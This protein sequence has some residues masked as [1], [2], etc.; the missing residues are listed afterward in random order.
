MGV[1]AAR[2]QRENRLTRNY[3]WLLPVSSSSAENLLANVGLQSFSSLVDYFSQ[4]WLDLL[5][6]KRMFN[7]VLYRKNIWA[8]DKSHIMIN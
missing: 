4:R 6:I 3:H 5:T 7:N 8:N 2:G 1:S